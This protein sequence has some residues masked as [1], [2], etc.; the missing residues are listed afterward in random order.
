VGAGGTAVRCVD[1][2][3]TV[4]ACP[5]AFDL[6]APCA[7]GEGLAYAITDLGVVVRRSPER[8]AWERIAGPF[9][10]EQ[11]IVA[12]AVV[13]DT[14]TLVLTDGTIVRGARSR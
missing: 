5:D 11:P 3:L 4:D 9:R 2:R 7:A 10:G 14:L 1:A 8:D 13:A 6:H 12:T